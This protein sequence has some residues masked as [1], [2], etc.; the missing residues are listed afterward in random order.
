MGCSGNQCGVLAGENRYLLGLFLKGKG[1][2][3]YYRDLW[4]VCVSGSDSSVITAANQ[5]WDGVNSSGLD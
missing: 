1:A 5:E 3:S 4:Q 2:Q